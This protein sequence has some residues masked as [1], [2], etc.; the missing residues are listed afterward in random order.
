MPISALDVRTAKLITTTQIITSVY[1]VVKELMENALD[2]DADNIEINLIDNGTSLI[3]V[4]DNGHGISKADVLYVGLP[5]YTSKISSFEDLD[6]LQTFGFR[7]EALNALCAVAEVIIITKTEED[8]VGTSYIMNHIGQIVKH[9]SCHRST[10]TTVQ[11]KNLFKQMPVRRQ[12]MTDTRRAN[13]VIKLLETLLHCFGICKSNVRIQFRVNNNL[14]FTKPS[15]NNIKEAVN[16]TLG[17]KIMSNMEWIESKD[18]DFVLQLMLPSKKIQDL[19]EVSHPDLHYIFVNNRPIKHKSLEKLVNNIILE[20]FK[21]ESHRKKVIFLVYIILKPIDIDVNLEPNKDTILFKDQ[22]KVF[23][24]VD[25]YMKKYYGL[26]S[27]EIVEQNVSNDISIC[28]EDY[29]LNSSKDIIDT[30]RPMCKKRK[31]DAQE[32][33]IQKHIVKEKPVHNNGYET[34]LHKQQ[35]IDL[36]QDQQH[37]KDALAHIQAPNLSDSDSNDIFPAVTSSN[38]MEECETLSQLPVIDLGEDFNYIEEIGSC[39]ISANKSQD[40]LNDNEEKKQISI[41]TWSKGHIIG[42][43]GGTDIQSDIAIGKQSNGNL[44]LDRQINEIEKSK[45]DTMELDKTHVDNKDLKFIKHVRSQITKENP[46]LTAAQ[47]AKKITEFWKQLSSNERGYYRDIAHN[48]EKE[49]QAKTIEERGEVNKISVEG[50]KSRLLQLFEKM[51]NTKNEKKEKLNMRT[52]V[53]WTINRTKIITRLN[54]ESEHIIGRL[55]PNLWIATIC[56]QIWIIDIAGL[57]N[58]LKIADIDTDK[59]DAKRIECL[60]KQWLSKRD[61]MSVMHSIYEFTRKL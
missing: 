12:I 13:Q 4:K 39:N 23:D 20:Y 59:I 58:G 3:E 27:V 61:D 1:A 30:E 26:K 44:N 34:S 55:T 49:Q 2:A 5:S 37:Y 53:P 10:G 25:K 60:L 51:K 28:Y 57:I 33:V 43:K 42:L 56:E 19:S 21:Q 47:T 6:T 24:T 45:S 48:K 32:K 36:I 22:S 9:E 11:A 16:H 17:R 46:T 8:V 15:L 38:K 40:K 7:G 31:I 14:V 35:N 18:T 54:F 29:I 52:I 50:N 41:E